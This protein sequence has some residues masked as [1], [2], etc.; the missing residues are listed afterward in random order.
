LKSLS[1]LQKIKERMK[2]NA[3]VRE[4]SE[5]TAKI[6]IGMATCGIAAG[7]RP[8]LHAISAELAKRNLE[9]VTLSQTGCIGM[10][11]YEPIVDV[12]LPNQDKVT[13]VKVSPEKVAKIISD[14]VVNGQPVPEYTVG[15]EK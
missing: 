13:Y 7:A 6:V 14:H 10:C 4:D 11:T 9:N 1:E 3:T 15:A 12:Y 8:V 5:N 2:Q